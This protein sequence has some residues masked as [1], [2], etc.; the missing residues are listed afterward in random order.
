MLVGRRNKSRRKKSD[1]VSRIKLRYPA[2]NPA[3]SI[4][5]SGFPIAPENSPNEQ[6]AERFAKSILTSQKPIKRSIKTGSN[7]CVDKSITGGKPLAH[8]DKSLFEKKMGRKLDKVRIHTG[9]KPSQM[10]EAINANAFTLG[11][12]IFFNSG[13]YQP[14]QLFGKKLLAHELRHTQQSFSQ[15]TVH[16]DIKYLNRADNG[17]MTAMLE[18]AIVGSGA[19]SQLA[20]RWKEGI[21]A[22]WSASVHDGNKHTTYELKVNTFVEPAF[23]INNIDLLSPISQRYSN[24]VAVEKPGYRSEVIQDYNYFRLGSASVGKWAADATDIVVAHESG[25][26]MGLEDKYMDA[27]G[28]SIKESGFEN[29]IM[30]VGMNEDPA[31]VDVIP[32]WNRISKKYFGK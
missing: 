17:S 13:Q 16:R 19:T 10:A 20:T 7:H 28:Y 5:Q 15:P 22:W 27:F 31:N 14:E 26:F 2:I 30:S 32:A 23:T 24:I 29:D 6:K 11:N 3:A 9:E 25:H 4:V 12:H 8:K 1:Q 18:I 21:E